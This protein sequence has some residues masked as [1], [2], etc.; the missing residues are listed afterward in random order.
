LPAGRITAA[1]ISSCSHDHVRGKSYESSNWLTFNQA[2]ERGGSVH[3]GEKSSLVVFWKQYDTTDRESGRD[4]KIPALRHYN[5]FNVVQCEG[6]AIPDA[7]VFTPSEFH[8]VEA[9]GVFSRAISAS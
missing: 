7:P 9:A 4:I 3:K 6:I 8:P 2:K 5:V 1:S